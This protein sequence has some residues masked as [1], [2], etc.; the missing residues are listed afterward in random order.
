MKKLVGYLATL[1]LLALTWPAGAGAES[2]EAS[3][4]AV[5]VVTQ[6]TYW[7]VKDGM[8]DDFEAGLTAHNALHASQNDPNGLHTWQVV[9]GKR[10]GTYIRVSFGHHWADFDVTGENVEA[11]EADAAVNVDPY[12]EKGVPMF[13]SVLPALSRL[14]P[15]EGPSGVSRVITFDVRPGK[16][17]AFLEA[18][19]KIH[20]AIVKTDWLASYIWYQREDG[21]RLPTYVVVLPGPDWASFAPNEKPLPAVLTEVYGAE[22]T[23]K[24]LAG[25][26]DSVE[27]EW[28]E[29]TV[30]RRDLS[31]LPLDPA[32]PA[33]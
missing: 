26:A 11:D 1:A 18:I 27:S 15:G 12:L 6:V 28:S 5:G 32:L 19:G 17:G 21:G 25:I 16:Q 31:Y 24:I 20:E 2:H 10:A 7:T 22:E 3:E 4:G 13:Y 14:P 30:Y 29:T 33:E 8:S 9:S 23:A